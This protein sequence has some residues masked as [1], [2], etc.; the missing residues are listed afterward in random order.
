MVTIVSMP[1]LSEDMTFG[2][3]V[4]WLK[5]EGE[6][7]QRGEPLMEIETEKTTTTV[8]SPATGILKVIEPE[9]AKVAV[10][11]RM[12]YISGTDEGVPEVK[13]TRH[14]VGEGLKFAI[15]SSVILTPT[16]EKGEPRLSPGA[17]RLVKRYAL[18]IASM[19]GT[20]PGGRIVT[21]DVLKVIPETHAPS[22]TAKVPDHSDDHSEKNNS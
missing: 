20:G 9:G 8:D 7:V 10:G 11:K 2:V 4:K 13:T 18:D 12:A 5:K 1:R 6:S 14:E 3:V 19:K 17:R 21:E 15:P 22:L 16:P